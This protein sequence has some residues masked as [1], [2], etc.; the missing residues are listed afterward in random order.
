MGWVR[1]APA[2]MVAAAAHTYPSFP[3]QQ[4]ISDGRAKFSSLAERTA[5]REFSL[6]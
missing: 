3:R 2:L 1:A 4:I 6:P 5:G